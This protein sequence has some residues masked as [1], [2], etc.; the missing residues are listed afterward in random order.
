M[1]ETVEEM[2]GHSNL[3]NNKVDGRKKRILHL[4]G[5]SLR[6]AVYMRVVS[7]FHPKN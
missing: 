4:S 6:D 3:L 5:T 7:N 1:G 2:V